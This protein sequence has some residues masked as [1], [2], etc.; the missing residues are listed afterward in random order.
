MPS[1]QV[2]GAIVD[3]TTTI[4]RTHQR[5]YSVEL[6]ARECHAKLKSWMESTRNDDGFLWSRVEDVPSESWLQKRIKVLKDDK[7]LVGLDAQWSLGL[8]ATSEYGLP[9]EATGA[10]MNMWRKSLT[11]PTS[12]GFTIRQAQ[13]VN[14][15]R[16]VREAGGS[17]IGAVVDADLMYKVSSAYT[18]RQRVAVD[19]KERLDTSPL[20]A[21]LMLN[22]LHPALNRLALKAGHT[23]IE[24]DD[25]RWFEDV[26]LYNPELAR[27]IIAI[28]QVNREVRPE[29]VA[30]VQAMNELNELFNEVEAKEA[31]GK[32]F[33]VGLLWGI[34]STM[35]GFGRQIA[36]QD[37]RW[38]QMVGDLQKSVGDI[39]D[40]AQKAADGITNAMVLNMMK[41]IYRSYVAG[42]WLE[43]EPPLDEL[44]NAAKAPPPTAPTAPLTSKTP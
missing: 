43:W 12:Q 1:K 9:A 29:L 36:Q 30:G 38:E 8:A 35:L 10:L 3:Q 32:D 34:A 22:S 27:S 37:P 7:P 28:N 24:G 17:D 40:E 13:W 26:R 42:E 20:D 2:N 16:W 11:A 44:F 18:A 6:T 15:L 25:N 31:E 21:N 4:F 5:M 19:T 41:D 33:T 14:R 39:G 23:Q